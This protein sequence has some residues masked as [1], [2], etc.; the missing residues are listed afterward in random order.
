MV[1][2][3]SW[4]VC[5]VL[6]GLLLALA[7]VLGPYAARVRRFRADPTAGYHA[8]FFVYVSPGARR[9]ARDGAGVTLLVQPNNS[10]V[11][12]DDPAVHRR[13]AWLMG[14]GRRRLAEELEVVLLVPAFVRP[15]ADW[16]IL[17]HALD[18]DVLTTTRSD[19]ARLDLQ[20]LAM[21]DRARATL[22]AE[23]LPVDESFLIQ[24]FSASGSFAARF[25]ALH[26]RRVRAA[27]IGAPGGWPIAPVASYGGEALPY[28][29]GVAD[30]EELTGA[31]F[32]AAGFAA[33]PKLFV[34]G[35]LDTNDSVDFRD[36][37]EEEPAALV[38]RLFGAD[39]VERWPRAEA[40]YRDAGGNAR[41]VLVDGVGHDRRK[42]QPLATRFF[43]EV[44][45]R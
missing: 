24:G 6:V 10:G 7:V 39:A 9:L 37:W 16:Q 28:P 34:L 13:D 36:G 1:V 2:L 31:P 33:V 18:R 38:H 45:G 23:G 17:S 20:L 11:N 4:L 44:L 43:A 27:A 42:L 19:L 12:S 21:V 14:F 35:S 29:V 30:L 41:F 32:D 26:P 22:A 40:I 25:T 15:A 8:D 5:F 3:L